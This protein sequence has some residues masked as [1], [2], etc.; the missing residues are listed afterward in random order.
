MVKY[1]Y[2][3]THTYISVTCCINHWS[4]D[5]IFTMNF[6][7][8]MDPE[9]MYIYIYIYVYCI[10]TYVIIL[11]VYIYIYVY[12][13]CTYV[14]TVCIYIYIILYV[15]ITVVIPIHLSHVWINWHRIRQ[16]TGIALRLKLHCDPR[17]RG[18]AACWVWVHYLRG[19]KAFTNH[20]QPMTY[21]NLMGFYG[22]LMGFYG[23]L[24]RFY[25]ILWWLNGI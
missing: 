23:D 12:C 9:C 10:C 3:Y 2:I 19:E 21:W 8:N 11:Y 13:I 15:Y 5:E 18:A 4:G 24:M 20:Q 16:G 6:P 25:G 1:I 22:D 17:R 7:A 14:Y